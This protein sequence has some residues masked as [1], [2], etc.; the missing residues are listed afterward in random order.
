MR[1]TE[2]APIEQESMKPV[3]ACTLLNRERQVAVIVLRPVR[4]AY[5]NERAVAE[6]LCGNA[7]AAHD[8]FQTGP[9]QVTQ[10]IEFGDRL[11]VECL[12]RRQSG[13]HRDRVGV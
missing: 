11:G 7:R 12:H 13:S 10:S 9:R 8:R 3:A 1:A 5:A 6:N 2:Y 4:K